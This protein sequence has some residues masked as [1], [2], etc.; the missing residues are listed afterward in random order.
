MTT[1]SQ[2]LTQA[3]EL[4]Q[5]GRF[6]EAL[7]HFQ[8][9]WNDHADQCTGKE[10]WSL[11]HCLLKERPRQ[12]ET[13]A[14]VLQQAMERW[15]EDELLPQKYAWCLYYQKVLTADSQQLPAAGREILKLCEPGPYS[16]Y[17]LTV[18]RV[19]EGLAKR[20][21]YPAKA[22]LTW[23]DLIQVDQL[24]DKPMRLA[25][26]KKTEIASLRERYLA[27][28]IKALFVSDQFETCMQAVEQGLQ[29]F[30]K[31]HYDNEVWWR[32]WAAKSAVELGQVTK[33]QEL[34]RFILTRRRDW[35]LLF[36]EAQLLEQQGDQEQA[37][38]RAGM[39]ALAPGEWDKKVR[40]WE[41]LGKRLEGKVSSQGLA[42][43]HF[44]LSVAL[45]EKNGWSVH[46]QLL[47][48][49]G[50]EAGA[51][52][53]IGKLGRVV[54]D[55]WTERVFQLSTPEKGR[56]SK[57]F[58]NG[59][60]GFIQLDRGSSVY[61]HQMNRCP[62]PPLQA[63]DTVACLLEEVVDPKKG[64]TNLTAVLIRKTMASKNNI[65]QPAED[66]EQA[67]QQAPEA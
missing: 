61:F 15:P 16:P 59:K 27:A 58:P 4:R 8:T 62:G 39:A 44:Q 6:S 17:A 51:R 43:K 40:L 14:A 34:Y 42:E 23:A 7:P 13:A 45:R 38:R 24:D 2:L 55:A 19:M 22:I 46:P 33:A 65:A 64:Q 11:A 3:H 49:A 30:S 18:L 56:I 31:L 26:P 1:F 54:Q 57:L 63:G 28:R 29:S 67:Q 9:L 32:R 66:A 37:L 41:W 10:A 48:R 36:E 5:A 47:E 21:S 50:V 52:L 35:F 20:P 25:G 60:A 53:P 12:T